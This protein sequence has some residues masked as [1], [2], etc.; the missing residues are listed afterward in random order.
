MF[1]VAGGGGPLFCAGF[2]SFKK[3]QKKEVVNLNR[4][5]VENKNDRDEILN[6]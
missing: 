4:G 2:P 3:W 1:C 6:H 5:F